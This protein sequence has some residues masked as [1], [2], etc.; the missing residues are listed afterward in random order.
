M[1]SGF[2]K[3]LSSGC[4]GVKH[5]EGLGFFHEGR[6]VCVKALVYLGETARARHK[7]TEGLS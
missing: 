7:D 2:M 3:E 5:T 4:D 6:G 1:G